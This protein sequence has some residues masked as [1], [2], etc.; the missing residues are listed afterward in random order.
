MSKEFNA[1]SQSTK[2]FDI[3]SWDFF[4]KMLEAQNFPPKFKNW[5]KEYIS[6]PRF[7]ISINGELAGFLR[8]VKV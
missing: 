8:A 2:L 4:L 6:T 5:V 7:S 3:V 1:E